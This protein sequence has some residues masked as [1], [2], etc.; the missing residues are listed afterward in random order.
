M[1]ISDSRVHHKIDNDDDDDNDKDYDDFSNK[2]NK[3][4]LSLCLIQ[5]HIK[6]VYGT[7][8]H[9]PPTLHPVSITLKM[10]AL[11]PVWML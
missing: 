9:M 5:H 6:K 3:V 4:N 11:K 7:E 10:W 8:L 1:S 2:D